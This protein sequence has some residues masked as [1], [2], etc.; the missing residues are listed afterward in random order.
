MIPLNQ[1]YRVNA[2]LKAYPKVMQIK[3]QYES[4]VASLKLGAK[5]RTYDHA[6]AMYQIDFTDK[7]ICE[8]G[9]RLSFLP[10]YLTRLARSVHA[11]DIFEGWGDIGAE[12]K[13]R[14]LWMKSAIN[15]DRLIV[16]NRDMRNMDY[17]DNFFDVVMSFSTIEH[18]KNEGDIQ[19]AKE[20]GRI[21]KPGGFIIIGTDMSDQYRNPY[22]HYYD[23]QSLFERI[24]EPTGCL[25]VGDY[26]FSW[27]TADHN[28][29]KMYDFWMTCCIFLL[30]KPR[31]DHGT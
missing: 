10:S 11:S 31:S 5:G 28:K 17:G 7:D 13:W 3:Q 26:D 16:S 12:T 6:I 24:V 22:R 20:M 23:E 2:T 30:Q 19:T 4:W 18:A 14:D 25:L 8:L 29:H 9:A 15:P 27:A 21:C 1:S